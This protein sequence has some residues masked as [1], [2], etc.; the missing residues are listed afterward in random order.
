MFDVVE[1]D[2]RECIQIDVNAKQGLSNT[3]AIS[4]LRF[5][6][7]SVKPFVVIGEFTA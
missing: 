6:A 3:C 7:T 4:L 5:S 2:E 1:I